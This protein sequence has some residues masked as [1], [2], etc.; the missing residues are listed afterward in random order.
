M[1]LFFLSEPGFLGGQM[2]QQGVD[3][4]RRRRARVW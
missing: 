2:G 1:V 3:E 4:K